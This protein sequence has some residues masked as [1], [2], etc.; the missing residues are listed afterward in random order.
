VEHVIASFHNYNYVPLGIKEVEQYVIFK[1]SYELK[2]FINEIYETS[3]VANKHDIETAHILIYCID[4]FCDNVYVVEL[5]EKGTTNQLSTSLLH[6]EEHEEA[7]VSSKLE[8]EWDIPP[9]LPTR[10]K[11]EI[12]SLDV[13]LILLSHPLFLQIDTML[14]E[15]KSDELDGS[16]NAYVMEYKERTL[17][18]MES[19]HI[20]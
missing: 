8:E 19:T 12:E 9:L 3:G 16:D 5:N 20:F 1:A 6:K 13:G 15:D 4:N 11:S 2:N 18:A 14:C 17:A 7:I 10:D